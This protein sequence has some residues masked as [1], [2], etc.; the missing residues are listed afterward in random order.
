M[1]PNLCLQ[2]VQETESLI[3]RAS[4]PR[5]RLLECPFQDCLLVL[6][7]TLSP[8]PSL[9]PSTLV[10]SHQQIIVMEMN[11][12]FNGFPIQDEVQNL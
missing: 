1:R 7:T 9:V 11:V 6:L 3:P 10:P 12:L 2:E 5:M 8:S 4:V